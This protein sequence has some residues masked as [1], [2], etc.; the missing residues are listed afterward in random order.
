MTPEFAAFKRRFDDATKAG[1]VAAAA[2][3]AGAVR[4]AAARLYDSG[5]FVTGATAASVQMGVTYDGPAGLRSFVG[6]NEL[7]AMYWELGH[8]NIFTR[9]YERVEYWRETL[10][11]MARL[12]RNYI[13]GDGA[14]AMG[15]TMNGGVVAAAVAAIGGAIAYG[16]SITATVRR[17]TTVTT[18]SSD[19]LYATIVAG[20]LAYV[21]AGSGVHSARR[22]AIGSIARRRRETRRSRSRS[23]RSARRGSR[24][25]TKA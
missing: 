11:L 22:S 4:Q 19:R 23:S 17:I 8:F 10:G 1:L 2:H 15:S 13:G 16:A 6:T 14:S 12:G 5:H 21:A 7:V 3:Y 9:K 20:A 24:T 18:V 25:A